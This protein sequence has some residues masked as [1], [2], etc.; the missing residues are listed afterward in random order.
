MSKKKHMENII[1]LILLYTLHLPEIKP[2]PKI[3]HFVP[4]GENVV[5]EHL[6]PGLEDDILLPGESEEAPLD[7]CSP[8]SSCSLA[9]S[10]VVHI[11]EEERQKYEME[12]RKLY[13]HLDDKVM[14]CFCICM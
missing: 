10:I 2:T 3:Q 8:C 14:N 9:S 13:K 12:I 7:I 4:S 11:S 1:A 5:L 6:N